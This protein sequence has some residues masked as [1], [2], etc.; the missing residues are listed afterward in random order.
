MGEKKINKLQLHPYKPVSWSPTH[1]GINL[2]D[3]HTFDQG[4]SFLIKCDK[5]RI[6]FNDLTGHARHQERYISS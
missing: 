2:S 6:N 3:R 5:V 1:Q 4:L